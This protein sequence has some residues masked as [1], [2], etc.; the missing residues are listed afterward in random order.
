[1]TADEL[2]ARAIEFDAGPPPVISGQLWRDDWDDAERHNVHIA[3]RLNAR[4]G[5]VKWAIHSHGEDLNRYGHWEYAPRGS[6]TNEAYLKRC[7]FDSVQEAFDVWT[8]WH[9]AVTAW[10]K[11]K[12]AAHKGDGRLILN[13]PRRLKF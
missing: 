7:R 11:K 4:T 13:P 2:L 1:M 10:A 12:I 6:R 9:A 8:R 5:A 3:K